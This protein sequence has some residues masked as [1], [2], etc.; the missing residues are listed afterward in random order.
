VLAARRPGEE[1]RTSRRYSN[2][3]ANM[4]RLL[5]PPSKGRALAIAAE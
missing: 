5:T 4:P 3:Y 1:R 2:P